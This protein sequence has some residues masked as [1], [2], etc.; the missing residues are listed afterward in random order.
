MRIVSFD[1][2]AVA[3]GLSYF[4]NGKLLR[5]GL[6]RLIRKDTTYPQFKKKYGIKA[7]GLLVRNLRNFL[8]SSDWLPLFLEADVCVLESNTF[9]FSIA[10][11]YSLVSWLQERNPSCIQAFVY[12][13]AISRHYSWGALSRTQRKKRIRDLVFEKLPFLQKENISQDEID[14]ICNIFYFLERNRQKKVLL[15]ECPS[16]SL[17]S[18]NLSNS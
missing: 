8:D 4:W 11:S 7:E 17:H 14:S 1:P 6:L 9:P 10:V 15:P 2:A 5:T 16:W 18:I 3:I 12:P 13:P